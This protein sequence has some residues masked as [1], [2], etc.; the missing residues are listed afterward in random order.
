MEI[1]EPNLWV[2][3]STC[4]YTHFFTFWCQTPILADSGTRTRDAMILRMCGNECLALCE[5]NAVSMT[6]GIDLEASFR[7]GQY[8]LV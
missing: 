3:M 2:K 7:V 4:T 1:P 8:A 6:F 5:S